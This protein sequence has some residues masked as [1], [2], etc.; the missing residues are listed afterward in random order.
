MTQPRQPTHI[1]QLDGS[2][3]DA[4][5]DDV[6]PYPDQIRHSLNRLNG[7]S[8]WG[9]SLW[10]APDGTD[11]RVEVTESEEYMQSAGSAEAMTIEIRKVDHE[12][13]A[14]QFTVGRSEERSTDDLTEVIAWDNGRFSTKVHPSEVFTA[15][16]AAKVFYTYFLH[17]DV[18][19]P[20]VLREHLPA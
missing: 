12:G 18:T 3:R 5:V 9:Y 7:S 8:E 19:E 1:R 16:E 14:H 10:R 6:R 2:R 17:G 20:Y 13:T 15:D 11:P 4:L